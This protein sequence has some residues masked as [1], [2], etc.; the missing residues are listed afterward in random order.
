M[1]AGFRRERGDGEFHRVLSLAEVVTA[2]FYVFRR[3][4][5]EP[6]ELRR[7]PHASPAG[8]G[9]PIPRLRCPMQRRSGGRAMVSGIAPSGA[10]GE[11]KRQQGWPLIILVVFHIASCCLLVQLE[12][13]H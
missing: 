13:V 8:Q 1:S 11:H 4:L 6:A 7:S 10:V 2:P 12:A 5:G 9:D 3:K